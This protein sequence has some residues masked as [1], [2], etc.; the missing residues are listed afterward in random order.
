MHVQEARLVAVSLLPSG[1][2]RR[3]EL[4][5][6][7]RGRALARKDVQW[8]CENGE[9]PKRSEGLGITSTEIRC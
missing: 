2:T 4:S 8:T 7:S 3:I 5:G 6:V 1:V 9:R